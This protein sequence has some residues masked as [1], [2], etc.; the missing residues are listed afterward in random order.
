[1]T[2]KQ[3]HENYSARKAI[4]DAAEEEF[5]KLF[6]CECGGQFYKPPKLD[7]GQPDFRCTFCGRQVEVKSAPDKY[8]NVAI[9]ATPFLGY[10][11][12]TWIVVKWRGHW[13]S[14]LRVSLQPSNLIPR[15]PSHHGPKATKF[16]LIPMSQFRR[17]R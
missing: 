1:M 3:W 14:Q 6:H 8:E 11:G 16:Y 15:P 4:G 5:L 17:L 10:S 13:W 12:D 9:S 7:P 2:S